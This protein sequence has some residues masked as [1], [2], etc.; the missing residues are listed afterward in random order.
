MLNIKSGTQQSSPG[1]EERRKQTISKKEPQFRETGAEPFIRA[2]GL[3]LFVIF[4]KFC[5]ILR[6]TKRECLL[7][8]VCLHILSYRYPL[9][10]ELRQ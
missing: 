5:S 8:L 2:L 1:T 7:C 3:K 4:V 10:S 6:P 9:Q